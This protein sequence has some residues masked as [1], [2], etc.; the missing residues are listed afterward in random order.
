LTAR[1]ERFVTEYL[2]DLKAGPAAIRAGYAPRTAET[3]GPR[4]LRF[5]QVAEAIADGKAKRAAE[6]GITAKRVLDE[7]EM[8]GFSDHTNYLVDTEGVVTLAPG[9]PAGA[10]RAI[11]SV[12]RRISSIGDE[13]GSVIS[14]AEVEIKLWD[15]PT[16]L[17]LAGRHVGLFPDRVELVGNGGGPIQAEATKTSAE[18]RRELAELTGV[19]PGVIRAPSPARNDDA[20]P[21]D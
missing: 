20:G 16:M 17:K 15:K 18:L 13:D 21:K 14:T 1:Q 2:I 9:A 5:A 6:T 3:C 4:L 11:A 19:D 12:K 10:H 7:L 8:L